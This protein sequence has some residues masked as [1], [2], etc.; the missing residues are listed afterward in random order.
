MNIT[1]SDIRLKKFLKT[2]H[3][4]DLTNRIGIITNWHD[5]P[6]E[7]EKLLTP[8]SLNNHLNNNG[9]LYYI[10][11]KEDNY[12]LF[13]DRYNRWMATNNEPKMFNLMEVYDDAGI[14]R[15]LGMTPEEL[16]ELYK[17]ED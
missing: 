14:P 2:S 12:L 3:G 5:L 15:Y 1:L 8:N 4:L 10:K 16:Y 7:F 13:P 9:P 17:P 11:G 6:I